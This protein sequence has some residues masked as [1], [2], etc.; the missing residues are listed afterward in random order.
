MIR[1]VAAVL[2]SFA[3]SSHAIA[4]TKL[5]LLGTGTPNADSERSG[6]SVAVVVDGKSYIVDFG[7]GVVRRAAKAAAHHGIDALK[8]ENLRTAFV[9]HLHT[10][11]TAG[12]PDLIFTP[13]VLERD[14]PLTV[15]GPKGTQRMTDHILKAYSEDIRM[16]IDGLEPANENG[17]KV[18]VDE[19]EADGIVYED[20]R[21]KVEA[22]HVCHG[23]WKH[24]LGYK[25][26]SKDK[27]IVISGDTA[28]CPIVAEKAKGADILLHEVYNKQGYDRRSYEWLR[29]HGAFHTSTVQLAKIANQARPKLVVLY[30]QLFMGRPDENE[31]L[32]EMAEHTDVPVIS[33]RDLDVF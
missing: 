15:I 11:H 17:W 19:V 26:V 18:I 25:F 22:F 7:P 5:V 29:Y 33:G 8:P 24:A 13:W 14:V 12:Y 21:V 32:A 28:A 10:D 20:D 4:E 2:L 6:P 9:T 30:H 16:R 3:L 1:F 23:G 27:T 31:L